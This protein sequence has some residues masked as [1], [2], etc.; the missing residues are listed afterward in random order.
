MRLRTLLPKL[1]QQIA[2]ATAPLFLACTMNSLATELPELECLVEPNAVVDVGSPTHGIVQ[3]VAVDRSDIVSR[4]AVLAQLESSAQHAAVRKAQARANMTGEIRAREAAL[5][6]AQ[7]KHERISELFDSDAISSQH[8]DEVEAELKM[9]RNQL[10][11]AVDT[12]SLARIELERARNDLDRRTI[13]S[14]ISGVVVERF[15]AA[16][17]YVNEKPLLRVAQIDPLRVE[18]IAPAD[19]F[20]KVSPGMRA[21]VIAETG[22][23]DYEA[24]VTVVDRMIDP[25]SG[26]FGI[27]L[28]LA[29]PDHA[30]PSGLNCKLQFLEA[31]TVA[32]A[33]VTPP[34]AASERA[35][36]LGSMTPAVRGDADSTATR[37]TA[38]P[39]V[40]RSFGPLS[41]ATRRDALAEALRAHADELRPR[42]RASD[43]VVGYFVLSPAFPSRGEARQYA[44]RLKARGIRDVAVLTRGENANRVSLGL[45]NRLKNA[46]QRRDELTTRGIRAVVRERMTT[47]QEYWLDARLTLTAYDHVANGGAAQSVSSTDCASGYV[48]SAAIDAR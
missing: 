46:E 42:E 29:N 17:E 24:R 18:A 2:C 3:E 47:N 10:R 40:C 48:Q 27:R 25:A 12:R 36:T 4:D 34:T 1:E 33:N 16:G 8:R 30:I 41:T 35:R 15:V 37:E 39:V 22:G 6:L 19:V 5:V 7:R 14:P 44:A 11:Q 9:A 32:A 38:M 21:R 23:Q 13:R 26:M 20:G 31:P 45:Y 28:E 43:Q